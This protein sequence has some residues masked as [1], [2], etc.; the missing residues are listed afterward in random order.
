MSKLER[1]YRLHQILSSRRTP[2]SRHELIERLECSQPT[3]YRL[4]NELRDHLGAPL[5][6]DEAHNFYYDRTLGPFELPGIWVSNE[7]IDALLSARSLLSGVQPG[8]L[9][10]E[11]DGLRERISN[12]L[13]ARGIDERTLADRIRILGHGRPVPPEHFRAVLDAL[14]KRHRLSIQYH[15]RGSNE[16]TGRQ[17]SPQRLIRYQD[18]WYLDGWC[19]LR[20]GLR[21]FAVERISSLEVSDDECRELSAAELDQHYASAYG[22]FSGP[23]DQ[24]AT[25]IFSAER[26]RWV[27]D[28]HWHTDQSATWLPDGRYQLDIP[29]H[30][31]EELMMEIMKHGD[32]VEVVSP[33]TLRQQ[34]ASNLNA[35]ATR[36]R[37]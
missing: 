32:H 5:E 14:V 7:E 18:N 31:S 29:F 10:T 13:D 37:D 1:L 28:E 8:L 19:H 24:R 20:Q 12:L 36:Y 15:A 11:L 3:V 26:A 9:E 33:E 35:A 30:H 21:S 27:A 6:Q 34:V 16:I 2:I 17:V 23:A 22:I 4:I 25:L